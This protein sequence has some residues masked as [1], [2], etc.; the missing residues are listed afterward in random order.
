M[1]FPPR[2]SEESAGECAK[3]R[4]AAFPS[5]SSPV[6]SFP[7]F[8]LW[9]GFFCLALLRARFCPHLPVR[10]YAQLPRLNGDS[11]GA[12]STK[13]RRIW[14]GHTPEST[15]MANAPVEVV[16]CAVGRVVILP[17]FG[18]DCAIYCLF[19]ALATLR[20]RSRRG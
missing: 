10:F 16:V 15:E 9:V 1:P 13:G 4:G 17:R 3:G 8:F 14:G 11:D 18:D 5:L 7:P 20:R 6:F 2:S 19:P 12:K